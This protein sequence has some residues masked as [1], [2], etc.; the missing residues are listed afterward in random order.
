MTLVRSKEKEK[1]KEQTL[2]WGGGVD[3][4]KGKQR[5]KGISGLHLFQKE[6]GTKDVRKL[7]SS[8]VARDAVAGGSGGAWGCFDNSPWPPS[9]CRQQL[10]Q[11][12]GKAD[13]SNRTTTVN[14]HGWGLMAPIDRRRKKMVGLGG[15][16]ST[17]GGCNR[18]LPYVFFFLNLWYNHRGNTTTFRGVWIVSIDRE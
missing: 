16:S 4:R 11:R 15:A 9:S 12:K 18:L 3:R 1:E 2:S 6:K 8:A 17:G 5:E 13:R 14:I 7:L 10:T